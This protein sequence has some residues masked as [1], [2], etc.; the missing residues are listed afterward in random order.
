MTKPLIML[1]GGGH[2]AVLLD[3][4][5]KQQRQVLAY[6]S[7]EKAQR[8]IFTGLLWLDN[9]EALASWSSEEVELVNGIGVLPGQ[10]LRAKLFDTF[11][12]RGYQFATV[13]SP[14]SVVSDFAHLAQGVQVF[15]GSVVNVGVQVKQNTIIN[16]GTVI[17]HDCCIGKHNHIAPGVTL[18]GGVTTKDNVHVGTGASIIQA[19]TINKNAVIGAG[20]VVTKDIVENMIVYPARTTQRL[21]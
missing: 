16:S 1:G 10:S 20:A 2:A 5:S 13:I 6:I 14:S 3:I 17:E 18:S 12:Q 19:V 4:L 7:P 8:A 21:R 11:S 9:D 15:P